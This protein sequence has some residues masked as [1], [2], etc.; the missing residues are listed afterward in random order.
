MN[1]QD[2]PADKGYDNNDDDVDVDNDTA[3]MQAAMGFSSF[4]ATQRKKRKHHHHRQDDAFFDGSGN[5]PL[6]GANSTVPGEAAGRLPSS[7]GL[8]A[9]PPMT[10][11]ARPKPGDV[12][13]GP[14]HHGGQGDGGNGGGDAHH[15]G[16]KPWW[17]GYYVHGSNQNPWETL[18]KAL[19][20]EAK[21]TWV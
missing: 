17:Q 20:L 14:S 19:G 5:A 4:G 1:D 12:Q 6:T 21:G 18:E 9:K 11:A 16:G 7:A 13:G 3:A 8:P 10:S 2:K 15:G